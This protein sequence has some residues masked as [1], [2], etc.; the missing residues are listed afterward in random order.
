MVPA[1][2]LI[3]SM[4][5]VLLK[6]RSNGAVHRKRQRRLEMRVKKIAISFLFFVFLFGSGYVLL[7]SGASGTANPDLFVFPKYQYGPADK[8]WDE[9]MVGIARAEAEYVRAVLSR[10]GVSPEY[11]ER[12]IGFR[13]EAIYW[14]SVAKVMVYH[15]DF[16]A[17]RQAGKKAESLLRQMAGLVLGEKT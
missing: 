11:K 17:A 12:I 4:K 3:D 7:T 6:L 5:S 8:V 10:G 14:D 1:E 2:A 9:I 13:D 15:S 16:E